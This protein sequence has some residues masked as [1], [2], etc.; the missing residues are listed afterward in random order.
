MTLEKDLR[1]ID[2]RINEAHDQVK[3]AYADQLEI[4]YDGP[5]Y[6]SPIPPDQLLIQD[7]LRYAVFASE[8]FPHDGEP[9]EF[10]GPQLR[11]LVLGVS[12]ELLL[13]GIS[14]DIE[15]QEFVQKL[16]RTSNTPGFHECRRELMQDL[17]KYTKRERETIDHVLKILRRHRNN[18]AHFGLEHSEFSRHLVYFFEVIGHLASRYAEQELRE[19]EHLRQTQRRMRSQ[20]PTRDRDI[21]FL[22]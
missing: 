5:E 20:N 18:L 1:W 22:I 8:S 4:E 2:K 7:A 15:P 12:A 19:L 13:T 11:L 6:D 14:L 3:A 21:V 16:E 10:T 17:D 9:A